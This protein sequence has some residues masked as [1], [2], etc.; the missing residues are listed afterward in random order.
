M[1]HQ[2]IC[3]NKGLNNNSMK[4]FILRIHTTSLNSANLLPHHFPGGLYSITQCKFPDL[5]F[6]ISI[7]SM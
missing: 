6:E 5:L 4:S 1:A 3:R 7:T 2:S